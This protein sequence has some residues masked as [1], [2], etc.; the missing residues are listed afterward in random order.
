[1][2]VSES[3]VYQ[4]NVHVNYDKLHCMACAY[5]YARLERPHT[6]WKDKFSFRV[7]QSIP[8]FLL[9]M[10]RRKKNRRKG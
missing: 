6:G 9:R 5:R 8:N 7:G 2:N 3:K 10:R 4:E 1:M